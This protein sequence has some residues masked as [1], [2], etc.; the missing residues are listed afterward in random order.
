MKYPLLRRFRLA[1]LDR[2]VARASMQ[3]C[4]K[5]VMQQL[6]V[7][8]ADVSRQWVVISNPSEEVRI[9]HLLHARAHVACNCRACM[10]IACVVY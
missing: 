1:E 2:E 7:S 6:Y 5:I 3:I 8:R 10:C 4:H 9:S